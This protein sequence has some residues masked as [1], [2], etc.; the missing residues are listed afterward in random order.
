QVALR[1]PSKGRVTPCTKLASSLRGRR[2]LPRVARRWD[3]RLRAIKQLA[4]QSHSAEVNRP[5]SDAGIVGPVWEMHLGSTAWE[6]EP[7][8]R[9]IGAFMA[10]MTRCADRRRDGFPE[11][12]RAGPHGPTLTC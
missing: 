8:E 6:A 4:E 1:P 7:H 9:P 3:R 11:S 10:V 12:R 5:G 2:S